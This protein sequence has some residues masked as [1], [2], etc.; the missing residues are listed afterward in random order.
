MIVVDVGLN[1]DIDDKDSDDVGDIFV[2]GTN[3]F[4]IS[5]VF[6]PFPSNII[7]NLSEKSYVPF[8]KLFSKIMDRK[9]V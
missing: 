1:D 7:L 3:Y 5:L 6:F 4:Y 8:T 2:A 9:K